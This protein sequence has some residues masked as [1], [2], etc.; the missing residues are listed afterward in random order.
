MTALGFCSVCNFETVE[1]GD[2][3]PY[4]LDR[5]DEFALYDRDNDGYAIM[6]CKCWNEQ[7]E[8]DRHIFGEMKIPIKPLTW[9]KH[10]PQHHQ[11][12]PPTIIKNIVINNTHNINNVN[13][14]TSNLI[15][16]YNTSNITPTYNT[17]NNNTTN[18]ITKIIDPDGIID[19]SS[20]DYQRILK[21]ANKYK[22]EREKREAEQRRREAEL[23]KQQE[24]FMKEEA[25][26]KLLKEQLEMLKN[27]DDDNEEQQCA[28]RERE[29]ALEDKRQQTLRDN[30]IKLEV[31]ERKRIN[32]EKMDKKNS[33][34]DVIE[35]TYNV[36]FGELS[37]VEQPIE[38]LKK[39]NNGLLIC[40]C[41]SKCRVFKAYPNDYLDTYGRLNENRIDN[42]DICSECLLTRSQQIIDSMSC[43]MVKCSCGVTYYGATIEARN[44][45]ESSSRHIKAL[46]RNKKIDGKTYSVLQLRK[47]CNVNANED[48]TL[49]VAGFSRMGK[50]EILERLLKIDNLVI[51]EGL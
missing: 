1:F 29:Q 49:K 2:V 22:A 23:K 6:C 42:K 15:P 9:E 35:K 41:C 39:Y 16:T 17:T 26:K 31:A 21:K 8:M 34:I 38:N 24:E 32:K 10:L 5:T 37:S 30:Q 12:A 48:G 20:S 11:Q 45:H 36:S 3:K 43:N 14:N 33:E 51:P 19:P 47:I 40:L 7:D 13:Y 44:K 46:G 28:L 27:Y 25:K 4:L 18:K 50:E